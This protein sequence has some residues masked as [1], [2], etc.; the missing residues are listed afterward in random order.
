MPEAREL[1]FNHRQEGGGKTDTLGKRYGSKLLA[2]LVGLPVNLATQAIIPRGLGP[3]AYGDF[4]FLTNFFTQ[5][6]NFLEMGT[7]LG[8]YTKLSQRPRETGL[9]TFYFYFSGLVV[10]L[11]F[12]IVLL[13]QVFAASSWIWPSQHL[14]YIYLAAGWGVLIWFAQVF[15]KMLDAYGLTVPGEKA[16]MVQK[17]LGLILLIAL[18]SLHLLHLPGLFLY[19]FVITAFMI[20]VSLRILERQGFSLRLAEKLS[21]GRIKD[22]S[23]EFYHFSHPLFVYG[24][25]AMLANIF[26]RWLL[27]VSHG[28][29]QQGFYSLSLQIGTICFLFTGAMTP[30]LTREF[31][32]AF[33]KEDWP[34]MAY[35]FQ[36]YVPLL[37][38]VAAFF[39]CFVA[40]QAD[41]VIYIMGGG[42]FQ[43]ALMAVTIMAFYPIYQTY[44]QLSSS[45]FYA[46]GKTGLYRNIGIA[47]LILG[48]PLTYLLI[49]P[50]EM[51][52]LGAGATGLAVKMVLVQVLGINVQLYFI[53][54]LLGVN[55]WRLLGHQCLCLGCLLAVAW[56]IT[57]MFDSLSALQGKIIYSFL[58]AGFTYSVVV[59]VLAHWRPALFGLQEHDFAA[60]KERLWNKSARPGAG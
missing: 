10:A 54:R 23:K 18:F 60:L 24:L 3:G 30:L 55:F 17:V 9:V 52:G 25:V 49:A 32:I 31:A 2:N 41:K 45:V 21:W 38:S 27:Q 19:Y 58:L 14:I 42:K 57:Y 12:A 15:E 6:F 59:L 13:S 36:R 5:V 28:S 37:Y 11:I 22:Y 48:L 51:M 29:V 8:F 33:G 1:T 7:S 50:R 39:S 40:L 16:R 56:S 20:V 26:D 46:T 43:G 44:G 47:F 53:S 35:L 4:N 34:Q